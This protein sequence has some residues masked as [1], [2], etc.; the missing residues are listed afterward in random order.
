MVF[1]IILLFIGGISGAKAWLEDEGIYGFFSLLGFLFYTIVG[2]CFG[3]LVGL[4]IA[5]LLPAKLETKVYTQNLECLQDNNSVN[6]GFFLGTGSIEG[7][8]KYVYYYKDAD[9]LYHLKQIDYANASIKYSDEIPK[10]ET[11]KEEPTKDFINYFAWDYTEDKYIIYI[12]KGSI[13]Q[14]FTLD[15]Q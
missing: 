15:A 6:G 8:M 7:K 10:I 13:K 2:A 9:S 11:Y 12:P 4:G 3:I 1:I 14:N 5:M